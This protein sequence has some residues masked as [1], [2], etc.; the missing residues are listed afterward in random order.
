MTSSGTGQQHAGPAEQHL[1][2]RLAAFVDGELPDDT[3]DRVLAHLVTCPQCKTAAD[4]QRRLKSVVAATAPPALPAGL[5][6]RLQGLPGGGEDD[7]RGPFDGGLLGG[8]DAFGRGTAEDFSFLS[9][10]PDFATPTDVRSRGFR[11]H[12]AERSVAAPGS[13]SRGRR[14]AFAAAGAFSMA[15]IALG[16]ALPMDT[17]LDSGA[18]PEE[19]GPAT[20]PL[21]ANSV[22]DPQPLRDDLVNSAEDRYL[23]HP[24]MAGVTPVSVTRPLMAP[25]TL[26]IAT[27]VPTASATPTATPG[28]LARR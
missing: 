15:A 17:A 2:D 13:A 19:Q 11:I 4:E 20:A 24:A 25:A 3:R 22:S 26:P 23:R 27:P 10:G 6:A 21:S 7:G 12:E 1:G 9:P 14:F 28:P 16:G 8:G 5:L 18:R